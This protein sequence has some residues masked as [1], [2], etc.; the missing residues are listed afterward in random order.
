[1]HVQMLWIKG[2]DIKARV[3]QERRIY[4]VDACLGDAYFAPLPR[5]Q[6]RFEGKL[7]LCCMAGKTKEKNE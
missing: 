6:T 1:M 7:G 4:F 2:I 5:S 3:L